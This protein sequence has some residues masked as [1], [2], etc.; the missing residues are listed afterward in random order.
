MLLL[1]KQ[2]QKGEKPYCKGGTIGN[3]LKKSSFLIQVIVVILHPVK[4][5]K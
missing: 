1:L 4:N 3:F 5:F 2:K